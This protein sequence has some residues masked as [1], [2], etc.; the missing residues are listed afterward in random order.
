MVGPSGVGK[1]SLVRAGLIP[2]LQRRQRWSVALVR[3][4]QDPWLRLAAGLLHAHNGPEAQ[5]TLEQSRREIDRLHAEGLAPLA[6]FLRSE[7]RP[8]L[9]VVD[10]L[11]ELLATDG[12]PDQDLLDLLLPQPDDVE[13]AVRIVLILRADFQPV[14]Q[15][16]PGFHTR[17]NERLYLLSPLTPGQLRQVVERPAAARGVRFEQGLV[18]QILADAAGGSLPVLEFTLTKLWETQRH[19]TLTFNGYHQM[20]GVRGALNRFADEKTAQLTHTAAHLLDQVLL[21][22]VRTPVGSANL[23]TRQRVF[24]SEVSS[25]EWQVV[26]RLA[27]ARLVTLG[28]ES[29]GRGPY[30]ELAHESLIAAWQRLNDLVAEN[31]EFLDWLARVGQRAAE[32]D[33]LPEERVAEARRWLDLRP[34]SVPNTVKTFIKASETA[35]EAR[36]RELRDARDRAEALYRR[37]LARALSHDAET[38]EDPVLALLLAIEVL[39]RSPDAQADRSIRMCLRRLGASEIIPIPT[40]T[41]GAAFDRARQRLTL[42]DWCHG[43]GASKHWL[44]SDSAACLIVDE[45][46][47][48]LYADTVVPM[49][50]PVVVAAYIQAGVACLGTEA[51]KLAVWHLADRAEKVGG[52]DLGVPITCVAVSDT[53]QT[54]AVA[55]DDGIIRA[56]RGE[57]LSDVGFLSWPGFIRDVDVGTDQLIAALSHDRRIRTWNLASHALISESAAS[58]NA[59]RLAVDSGGD[60]VIVGDTVPS[61]RIPLSVL[62]LTALARRAAGRDLTADERRRYIGDAPT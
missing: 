35:A 21:R 40:E 1:S 6:R 9:V 11:E 22:L 4:G 60:H 30:A 47:Q 10:Q 20:G 53:A 18:E 62:A 50:G 2:A 16:I 19:K 54:L 57:D 46:G 28:T 36:L 61:G 14:L 24:Q 44:L 8:L 17:L 13:A 5:V 41:E 3:P 26:R 34:D 43:P 27:E 59:C 48:A 39:E 23:A 58:T 37:S 38:T 32:G 55:C 31:A 52:R 49:P 12:H 45:R 29:A 51:G 56:L 25:A 42:C 15:S 7:D 33:P